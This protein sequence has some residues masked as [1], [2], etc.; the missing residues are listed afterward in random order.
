MFDSLTSHNNHVYIDK[1]WYI[2]RYSEILA[3]KKK[4]DISNYI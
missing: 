3:T 1:I 4:K 2:L